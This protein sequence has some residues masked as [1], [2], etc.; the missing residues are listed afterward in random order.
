MLY[1]SNQKQLDVTLWRIFDSWSPPKEIQDHSISWK[2]IDELVPYYAKII[3]SKYEILF[4]LLKRWDNLLDDLGR[5]PTH[6]NWKN[7]RPLRLSREE[8]WSDW[9]AHLLATSKTG[10]FAHWLFHIPTFR[11]FDYKS[12]RNVEREISHGGYRADIIVEWENKHFSHVEVKVGDEHLSKTINTSE[13]LREKYNASSKN[14]TNFIL[15][16]SRQLV[17]W[18]QTQSSYDLSPEI[19]SLTWDDVCV[20]IRQ[21]LL[22]EETITWKVW[23][24]SFLGAIEQRLIGFPGHKVSKMPSENLDEKIK[25]LKRGL[26]DG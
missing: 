20:A 22:T 13:N 15:L 11:I 7:F 8:D 18:E 12:P 26:N 9:L 25:I 19:K 2:V 17:S 21:G 24:Y 1:N 16:L 23:G 3:E 4:S 10:V 14:W 6:N 5:D